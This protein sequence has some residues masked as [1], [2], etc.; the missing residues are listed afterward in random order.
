MLTIQLFIVFWVA[1]IA[2][3]QDAPNN[4][5]LD[6]NHTSSTDL[7]YWTPFSIQPLNAVNGTLLANDTHLQSFKFNSSTSTLI[8]T[9]YVESASTPRSSTPSFV[10]VSTEVP[11]RPLSRVPAAVGRLIL[12]LMQRRFSWAEMLGAVCCTLFAI[13]VCG[14]VAFFVHFALNRRRK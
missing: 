5:V 12:G 10:H 13:L 2:A 9:S 3:D 7:P 14:Y 6:T 8:D 1:P 11:G 4:T